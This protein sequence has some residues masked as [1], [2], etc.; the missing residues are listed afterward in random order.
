MRDLTTQNQ[1]MAA[2]GSLHH[3][4]GD[5]G[6]QVLD[7]PLQPIDQGVGQPVNDELFA[8]LIP[9][10]PDFDDGLQDRFVFGHMAVHHR[11]RMG[12]HEKF[13]MRE[14]AL[15][16]RLDFPQGGA[17]RSA[18]RATQEGGALNEFSVLA[19]Y[20]LDTARVQVQKLFTVHLNPAS[21]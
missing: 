7:V 19:V 16:V 21:R 4:G 6:I 18:P 5:S 10:A 3:P 14:M 15:T 13:F 20:R 8:V 12:A 9:Q 2:S 11:I 1:R 17:H